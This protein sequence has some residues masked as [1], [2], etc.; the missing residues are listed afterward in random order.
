MMNKEEKGVATGIDA[1]RLAYQRTKDV[2]RDEVGSSNELSM[3]ADGSEYSSGLMMP[4]DRMIRQSA[5]RFDSERYADSIKRLFRTYQGESERPSRAELEECVL[6]MANWQ[7]VLLSKDMDGNLAI[8]HA[9][10]S[11]APVE[12]IK[13]LLEKDAENKTTRES[14][15]DGKVPLHIA[16]ECTG[17]LPLEVFEALIENDSQS[18][19]PATSMKDKE[20]C[21]PLHLACK[22][23]VSVKHIKLL[24]D[25]DEKSLLEEN[26][27][28]EL[29]LHVACQRSDSV[30]NIEDHSNL[31][32]TIK[33]L[34]SHDDG[35]ESLATKKKGDHLPLHLAS[36]SVISDLMQDILHTNIS[37]DKKYV[38]LDHLC[39]YC[40]P[41]HFK[42][43]V[44]DKLDSKPLLGWMNNR[45]CR[46][47][48][49]FF[50]MYDLYCSITWIIIFIL[51]SSKY[52]ND[53]PIWGLSIFLYAIAFSILNREIYHAFRFHETGALTSYLADLWNWIDIVAVSLVV[54]ST[55]CFLKFESNDD[56]PDIRFLLVATA[57]FQLLLLLSNLKNAFL[58]FATFVGGLIRVSE[59]RKAATQAN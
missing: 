27:F 36:E 59:G 4:S 38:N 13:F 10:Q 30:K 28:E 55:T 32:E 53:E 1:W 14:N 5:M 24:V 9:C 20:G 15:N 45:S 34:I 33:L 56:R 29:P 49:V 54:A 39:K 22:N 21:L 44:L 23:G 17:E 37:N 31:V 43:A 3:K 52:L 12:T 46:R 19:S 26:N 35:L 48:L 42:K 57:I 18:L 47:L 7:S 8:H 51:A 58:P 16:C 6:Y 25:N 11:A 40:Y 50:L 2:D 41:E